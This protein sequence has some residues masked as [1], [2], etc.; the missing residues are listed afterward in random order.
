MQYLRH[1]IFVCCFASCATNVIADNQV[2][3]LTSGPAIPA[4]GLTNS[5]GAPA[6]APVPPT[7]APS[8][9]PTPRDSAQQIENYDNLSPAVK[10]A[11]S[12][13]LS[14]GDITA[15]TSDPKAQMELA[16]SEMQLAQNYLQQGDRSNAIIHA[17]LARQLYQRLYGNPTDPRLIPIYS[18]LVQIYS[19]SYDKDNPNVDESDL[20]KAK[21]YREIIDHIHAE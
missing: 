20:A 6:N 11:L 12:K 9:P 17:V 19:S 7:P 13:A 3:G 14:D 8:S 21:M 16:K 5:P 10:E 18:L 4:T 2:T 15:D 1:L